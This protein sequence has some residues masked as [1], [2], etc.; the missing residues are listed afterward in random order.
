MQPGVPPLCPTK[1]LTL[2]ISLYDG[3]V[4]HVKGKFMEGR[5]DGIQK[6]HLEKNLPSVEP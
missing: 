1:I 4:L 5:F 3:F 6:S 2:F